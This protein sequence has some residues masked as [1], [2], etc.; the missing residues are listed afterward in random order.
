VVGLFLGYVV[1]LA[2]RDE[3]FNQ[4]AAAPGQLLIVV[5]LAVLV[6]IGAA[7]YPAWRAS[8]LDILKS[9]ATE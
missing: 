8:R 3:G 5:V 9:I 1:F 6:G 2:L 7:I 4:F